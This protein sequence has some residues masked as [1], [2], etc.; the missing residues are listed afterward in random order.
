MASAIVE[1]IEK[2]ANSINLSNLESIGGVT[3]PGSA[4]QGQ[5][6][7]GITFKIQLAAGSKRLDTKPYN[8]K[9]LENVE[10]TK[11]DAM[12]KYYYGATSDYIKINELHNKAKQKGYPSS[13]IVAFKDGSKSTVNEALKSKVN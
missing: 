1:A 11:E 4:S 6:Y 3:T 2:Y 7:E 9:G 10:R 5:V 12:Y 13:Y 8:F